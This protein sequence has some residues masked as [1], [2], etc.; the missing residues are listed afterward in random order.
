MLAPYLKDPFEFYGGNKKLSE[1]DQIRFTKDYLYRAQDAK[2]ERLKEQIEFLDK[3]NN[4]LS[5]EE[6]SQ[7]KRLDSV[8]AMLKQK[9]DD[10]EIER[11]NFQD[12]LL[13][14]RM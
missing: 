12:L 2:I 3:E 1:H 14:T 11:E 13:K 7:R 9:D 10:F 5:K 8:D 4:F 6:E